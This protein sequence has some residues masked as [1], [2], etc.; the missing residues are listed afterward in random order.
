MFD[1]KLKLW[2]NIKTY[3]KL[4]ND[5]PKKITFVCRLKTEDTFPTHFYTVSGFL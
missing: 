4:I 5:T 3:F 1:D 2:Y